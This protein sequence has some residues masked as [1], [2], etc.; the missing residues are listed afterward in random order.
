MIEY[1]E[2]FLVWETEPYRV[3]LRNNEYVIQDEFRCYQ[4]YT[5]VCTVDD[6]ITAVLVANILCKDYLGLPIEHR[7]KVVY[8]APTDTT[9]REH[10]FMIR[11][12]EALDVKYKEVTDE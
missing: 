7:S 3:I 10:L 2:E 5:D 12:S 1:N 9:F 8:D 11:I 6:K 4:R